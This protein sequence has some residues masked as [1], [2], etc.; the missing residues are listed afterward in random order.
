MKT[1]TGFLY[2]PD[3][4]SEANG[5]TYFLVRSEEENVKFLG[6]MGDPSGLQGGQGIAGDSGATTH[7]F[8]L[9]A[10]NAKVLRERLP[11]LRAQ[12]L[13]LQTSAGFGDRLGLATPGHVRA[14]EGTGIAPI[15][16]ATE[17]RTRRRSTPRSRRAAVS[18]SPRGSSSFAAGSR[19]DSMD[20]DWWARE[21]GSHRRTRMPEAAR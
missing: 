2:Y 20:S 7:L 18:P 3:S 21:P 14:V 13:G 15:F 16:A 8:P 6:V 11:W 10:E 9:T 5:T 17:R 4:L 19:S 12:P 1:L